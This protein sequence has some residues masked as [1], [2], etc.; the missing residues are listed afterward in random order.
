M[1]IYLPLPR[2]A[3]R[4]NPPRPRLAPPEDPLLPLGGGD[5]GRKASIRSVQPVTLPLAK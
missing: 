1:E 5:L 3:P 4:E 2:E